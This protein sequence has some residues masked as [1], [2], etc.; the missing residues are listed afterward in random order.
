MKHL[1]IFTYVLLLILLASA[2]I[3]EHHQ[4]S[5]FVSDH[6]YHTPW[7]VALWAL[8]TLLMIYALV[9]RKLWHRLP[10]L[11]LHLSFAVILGGGLLTYFTST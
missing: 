3:I 11:M 1:I 7:F 6:I 10:L 5:A 2:T 9:K 4:G 8:A